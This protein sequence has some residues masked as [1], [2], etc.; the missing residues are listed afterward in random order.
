[1]VYFPTLL[2][3][4]A[5]PPKINCLHSGSTSQKP[6]LRCFPLTTDFCPTTMILWCTLT[7]AALILLFLCT[8]TSCCC[9]SHFNNNI[10]TR[11]RQ[12]HTPMP[13]NT[14]PHASPCPPLMYIQH[15]MRTRPQG[16][17]NG[18]AKN[19][20]CLWGLLPCL[21]SFKLVLISLGS[22]TCGVLLR[23]APGLWLH[24]KS[25]TWGRT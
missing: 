4:L 8:S 11:M 22:C 13:L 3:F 15:S 12:M 5:L 23:F 6:W 20:R 1:M 14:S 18:V 2:V 21:T 7:L 16:K 24:I 10:C 25:G 9:S 17:W 19:S